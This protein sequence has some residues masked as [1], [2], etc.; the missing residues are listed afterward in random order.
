MAKLSYNYSGEWEDVCQVL[1]HFSTDT[2]LKRI[3]AEAIALQN[4]SNKTGS[5]V[6]RWVEYD[7]FNTSTRAFE[8]KESALTVW[9]LIDLAYY[10]IVASNDYRGERTI[11]DEEFYLLFDSVEGMKQKNE[12]GF[13]NTVAS[14]SKEI[15]MYLCG[16]A[17]E[18]FKAQEQ[19]KI[20]GNVGRELYILF[21][22]SKRLDTPTVDVSAIV[23]EETGVTWEKV[24]CSLLL[25][26]AC[27]GLDCRITE[28]P[29]SS[30]DQNLLS[31]EEYL[32]VIS[33][34]SISYDTLRKSALKRQA[35]YTR[36]YI[37]TQ[38]NE[39]LGI[40]PYLN[41]CLYEHA[42]LWIVR[43]HFK[44][45][46]DQGFTSYFGKCFEKYF[47]ELLN[48]YLKKD[49]FE[50]LPE[51]KIKRADWRLSI[52]GYGFLIEQ[53]SSLVRLRAK[54]QAPS[55]SDI[56]DYAKNTLIKAIRQLDNTEKDLASGRF[57]KII[58]LYEDYLIPELLD[59]A[60]SM[61]EC[62]VKSDDH[63][64][65]VTIEEMEILL[66][67][68]AKDRATFNSVIEEKSRRESSHSNE[69]RSLLQ[70]MREFDVVNNDFLR[71]EG[72]AHYSD[73]AKGQLVELL[74][75]PS[76]SEETQ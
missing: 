58:L 34:Y 46:D 30:A 68:C 74:Q 57:I 16:F 5:S 26:W 73:L 22:S 42:I 50:K 36:P 2:V 65:L 9:G 53:K 28:A 17:G 24:L 1:R 40:I 8:K 38:K 14:G 43:D 76:K 64:W 70:I 39:T 51:T 44:K 71:R 45:L 60:F 56:E 59:Q 23:Q 75:Q 31:R 48:C 13:L 72:I 37:I 7:R 3:S 11:S 63:Y 25:G 54:Q 15:I 55:L 21:E 18:Q 12:A 35:L 33:K 41:H 19:H 10:A 27:S 49:E 52:D 47:E 62:D 4:D 29:F 20:Y 67:L 66:G 32:K 6:A 69:G 61:K